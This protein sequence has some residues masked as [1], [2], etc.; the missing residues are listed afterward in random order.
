MSTQ[1]YN[2]FPAHPGAS[3]ALTTLALL[4]PQHSP[5]FLASVV[6]HWLSQP[7][8][9][10]SNG[11]TA[12]ALVQRVS[13]KLLDDGEAGGRADVGR[14]TVAAWLSQ[15][16][17]EVKQKSGLAERE[18]V[19]RRWERDGK[20]KERAREVEER[21][22]KAT[23][24]VVGG[25]R[26]DLTLARNL[27]LIR[28]HLLFPLVPILELRV[29]LLGLEHSFLYLATEEVL[30][31]SASSSTRRGRPEPVDLAA[32]GRSILSSLRG[33]FSPA[34]A[35]SPKGKAKEPQR[36][37]PDP[38]L[39]PSDLFHS[40]SYVHALSTHFSLLF[41]SLLASSIRRAVEEEGGSYASLRA[42]FELDAAE[43]AAREKGGRGKWWTLGGLFAP[44]LTPRGAR[45]SGKE[46]E[47]VKREHRAR[48]ALKEGGSRAA[49]REA[50]AYYASLLPLPSPPAIEA[51]EQ[52]FLPSSPEGEEEVE[53]QCCFT[54]FSPSSPA[55]VCSP[56]SIPTSDEHEQHTFC[57]DCFTAYVQTFTAGGSPLPSI[58]LT[59]LT[60][61]CFSAASTKPCAGVLAPSIL[62]TARDRTT[63]HKLEDRIAAANLELL[64]SSE[65]Y[66]TLRRC[67]FCP[68]AA[69]AAPSPSS[70]APLARIFAPAWVV[71]FPPSPLDIART[72]AGAVAFVLLAIVVAV[73]VVL[74]PLRV[75]ALERA[76]EDLFP[77]P[78]SSAGVHNEATPQALPL[79][80][81][82]LLSPHLLLPFI[83][84]YLRTITLR[85]L[86]RKDGE[87][88]VF[89]CLND[90]RRRGL[91]WKGREGWGKAL[92]RAER[93]MRGWL[94]SEEGEA[95]GGD[96]EE[97]EEE[98]R[99][100]K[101]VALVWGEEPSHLEVKVDDNDSE[102]IEACGKL[103]C[104]L[105]LSALN[106]SAPSLHACSS[107]PSSSS[108][109]S[110][111]AT[112]Q[113]TEQ[114][115]AEE[116]LRLAVERAMSD[117]VKREC[118]R[119]GVGVVKGG[120]CN[121]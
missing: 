62:H 91:G 30:S 33:V 3:A 80:T 99:R 110:T 64:A 54:P 15:R 39:T 61:P 112:S 74:C 114:E 69:L 120:G 103:S 60:L 118:P 12:E 108:S 119:C 90:G 19:R 29:L 76:W 22:R 35:A 55:I 38:L 36:R 41:P 101:L 47:D 81:A 5:A 117:A 77:A 17:K 32:V 13:D 20:G 107:S 111:T 97:E 72:L 96:G 113:A 71:P 6:Q 26:E 53:C 24:T 1:P 78:P 48:V 105:C 82:L 14:P 100:E 79:H 49:E 51:D 95:E 87:R 8:S 27:A 58:S 2:P 40:P 11:W 21:G 56:S 70:A 45:G 9:S 43:K 84:S 121:K 25:R 44:S 31:R 66:L 115:R 89:R 93:R 46:M 109:S 75:A 52:P 18:E 37:E 7:S 104:T 116:S 73:F 88:T 59:S 23:A 106:P 67:P 10:R 92:E 83:A 42:R 50:E 4:F 57:P 28:L 34:P 94:A 102:R 68:Y 65:P 85:V 98:R 86:R 16:A 63:R